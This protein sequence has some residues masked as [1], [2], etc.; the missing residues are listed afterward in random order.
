MLETWIDALC[1]VW[2]EVEAGNGKLVTSYPLFRRRE[3]PAAIKVYPCALTFVDRVQPRHVEGAFH[4][5]TGRTEF[6]FFES[7]DPALLP[8]V[9]RFYERI[10]HAAASHVTL[11]GLV[12]VFR[13]DPDAGVAGSLRLVYGTEAP[14]WGAIIGWSV[15]EEASELYTG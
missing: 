15:I 6:H 10:L 13:I 5:W 7:A 3:F 4:T 9:A 2:G 11:G 1:D 8:D 14:H 12:E